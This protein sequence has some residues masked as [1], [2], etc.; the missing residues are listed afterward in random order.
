MNDPTPGR[1][2]VEDALERVRAVERGEAPS[3]SVI[4][5]LTGPASL[6]DP[7]PDP[8]P[9]YAGRLRELLRTAVADLYL[10]GEESAETPVLVSTMLEHDE[11]V[12]YVDNAADPDGPTFATIRLDPADAEVIAR[13]WLRM[14]GR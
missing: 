2:P 11:V 10:A 1:I 6:T 14:V 8:E 5:K 12:L 13:A 7:A 3:G 9:P 4:L